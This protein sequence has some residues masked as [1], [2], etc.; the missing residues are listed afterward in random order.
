MS[1]LTLKQANIIIEKTLEKAR[2]DK[3][4]PLAVV[5]LDDS[6]NIVSA[7][8]ED[9]ASMFRVDIGLGKAWGA[10]AMSCSSRS[11][12]K[13]AKDNPGFFMSLATAAKGKFLPQPGAVLIRDAKDA[14]LGAVGAS[15]GTGPEDEA[16]CAYGVEQ[17]G[18]KAEI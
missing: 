2:E 4:R 15:G 10:V 9:G 12:G 6:G 16:C 5:V 3:I 17:A 1:R 13:R 14:I 7:Q 18:L 11:L 8:R